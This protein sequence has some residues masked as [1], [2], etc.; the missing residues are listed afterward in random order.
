MGALVFSPPV[1]NNK[2]MSMSTVHKFHVCSE[3][4]PKL[5]KFIEED[6]DVKN[7]KQKHR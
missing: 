6:V 7:R 1:K 5:L 2:E 3:C 4:W